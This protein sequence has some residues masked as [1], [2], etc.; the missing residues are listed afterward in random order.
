MADQKKIESWLFK[1]VLLP[2][3]STAC[4]VG[5]YKT[6]LGWQVDKV[7]ADRYRLQSKT[8]LNYRKIKI[9]NAGIY[10]NNKRPDNSFLNW[11]K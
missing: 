3:L 8:M 10:M 2:A 6:H 11:S 1:F 9:D 7:N 4:L 5:V